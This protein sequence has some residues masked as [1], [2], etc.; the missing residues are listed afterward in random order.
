SEDLLRERMRVQ[1]ANAY[2]RSGRYSPSLVAGDVSSI[3]ALYRSNGFDQ[4]NVTTD[5]QD[6]DDAANG[7]PL[8]AA[9][10]RVTYIVVEGQQQKFGS[11]DLTGVDSSRTKEI[12]SLMNSQSGQP[13][14]LVTLSGDRDAVLGYY[15]SHG[16]DQ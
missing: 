11:I 7:K 5:V 4:A 16:F 12:K 14:S 1:K 13:F 10:I 15:L 8:K 2:L 6:V 9:Q 3:E